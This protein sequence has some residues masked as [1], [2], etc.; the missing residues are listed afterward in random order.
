MADN[1]SPGREGVQPTASPNIRTEQAKFDPH[2][3]LS[4][5]FTALGVAGPQIDHMAD[6]QADKDRADGAAFANSLT[7]DELGKKIKSGELLPSQSPA[8]AATV[9]HIYGQNLMESQQRDT[10]LA[11]ERGELSFPDNASLEKHLVEQRNAAL[12]G[13]SKFTVAGFDKGWDQ[14]GK[15]L[16]NANS[17]IN[18]AAFVA[19]GSQEASTHLLGTVDTVTSP[20]FQ[21]TP[22]DAARKLMNQH[23]MLRVTNVLLTPQQ[24]KDALMSVTSALADGGKRAVLDEFL[25]QTTDSGGTVLSVIGGEKARRLTL[26]AHSADD[27]NQRQRVDVE[28]RPFYDAA[29][30]GNLTGSTLQAFEAWVKTNDPWVTTGTRQTVL[31][32]QRAFDHQLEVSNRAAE[33]K[34]LVAESEGAAQQVARA[35]IAGGGLPSMQPQQVLKADGGTKDF[36]ATAFAELEIPRL[37]AANKLNETQEAQFWTT[38]NVENPRWKSEIQA[39]V[40][41]LASVGW[42]ADGKQPG[43][44][45]EQGKASLARY[46][47]LYAVN[48]AV[49]AKYAG[50]D[51]ERLDSIHFLTANGFPDV[52]TA[53]ELVNMRMN[54]GV[55]S[56]DA[57]IKAKEIVTLLKGINDP[58]LF[59]LSNNSMVSGFRSLFNLSG[60][61]DLNMIE[62]E[63]TVRKRAEI[64]AGTS[65]YPT[66]AAAVQ[67]SLAYIADPK[68]TTKINNTIYFNKDLPT[69]P[70][71]ADMK[72]IME[73]FIATG[74]GQVAAQLGFDPRQVSM[75]SNHN[76]GF[77]AMMGGVPLSTHDGTGLVTYSKKQIE[78][79]AQTEHAATIL[80]A[81]ARRNHDAYAERTG[82]MLG[83][84]DQVIPGTIQY[85]GRRVAM[86]DFLS[87]EAWT[88]LKSE[89]VANGT[90]EQILDSTINARDKKK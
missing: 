29:Y 35:A 7:V 30:E 52:N 48:P 49:A 53:A 60:N 26:A 67:A 78:G 64:L 79:W 12:E 88:R 72:E 32:A 85:K 9:Q 77:V 58:S 56:Q 3:G 10:L 28:L 80:T 43:E 44:L 65:A 19:R 31:N 42:S 8:Y 59:S 1:Y 38:N 69:I 33:A 27:V 20:D 36:N 90:I 11:V 46:A 22:E 15:S 41:N 55:T 73:G 83:K 89:G 24:N 68:V 45:N 14:F 13:Q 39:G 75:A 82:K 51:A 5:L 40:A 17:R 21:G 71:G 63:S 16:V 54:G 34:R 25:K 87:K 66:A 81:T 47:Q 2:T 6:L 50:E 37:V 62:V 61:E 4:G 18:D 74:P 76:G 23:T 57:Q 84:F 86:K 70:Q